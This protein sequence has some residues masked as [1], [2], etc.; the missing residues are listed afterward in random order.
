MP[1]GAGAMWSIG[2]AAVLLL[3]ATPASGDW[4]KLS[5]KAGFL[6]ERR[7]VGGSSSY[8]IRVTTHSRLSPEAIFTTLWTQRD[9]PQF[10]PHL[11][12]L[13]ILSD[14]GDEK[15]IYEQIAV[16]LA[17]DRDYTVRVRKRV[18]AASQ[19]YEIAFRA[20]NDAGP[21]PDA[22]YVRV[23]RIKGSWLIE[24]DADGKGTLLRYTLF[25]DPGGA[26]PKW[27]A[28]EAQREGAA[29]LVA[30]VLKRA[31]ENEIPGIRPAPEAG[32][33]IPSIRR[34]PEPGSQIPSIRR[35]P[36]PGSQTPGIRPTPEAGSQTPSIRPAP[37]AGSQT[38][39]IRPAPEPGSQTPG[40]RPAPEAGSQTPGIRPAPEA[41]GPR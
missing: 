24:P 3:L 21:A 29:E 6:V 41:A 15:V 7:P 33:Q 12:Q 18:D 2:L 20:A 11:K 8:E 32:S 25:T 9:Y 39:G 30:A 37:E 14:T 17:R 19:R 28:N 40:I 27:V 1:R 35:A 5:D 31:R 38:P 4:E 34:A 23:Q 26:I 16:P 10:I 13:D 22:R 36:E